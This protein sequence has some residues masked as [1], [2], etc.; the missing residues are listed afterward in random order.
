MKRPP[1]RIVTVAA[2]AAALLTG[3][4]TYLLENN[5][6]SFSGLPS[7]PANPTFTFERL[8]SQAN[9]PAQ[10]QVESLADPALFK[11]GL[12]RDDASPRYAVQVSA[13]VQRVLSPWYDPWDSWGWGGWGGHFAH[14]HR[15]GLGWGGPILPRSDQAWFQRE[16]AVL[17]RDKSSN[18]VVYETRAASDGP[19]LDNAVVLPAMF[20]AAL[21]GFPTPPQGVRR[22]NIQ[23]GGE[24]KQA[25]A[26]APAASP[27]PS[28]V[29]AA[30][31]SAPAR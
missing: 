21:Q 27:Q 23:L 25:Q 28:A 19:W 13:R 3:C 7:L 31:A 6:Q 22:V 18:Q 15:M 29:P 24:T 16:V 14:G 10:A 1:S 5:V 4:G 11:A 30:P 20:D 9:Q 12:R 26:A 8:P 17:V 2:L